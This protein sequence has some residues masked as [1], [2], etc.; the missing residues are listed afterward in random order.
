MGLSL[1]S[2]S[3]KESAAEIRAMV[4]KMSVGMTGLISARAATVVDMVP[5]IW[6]RCWRSGPDMGGYG[7]IIG[8]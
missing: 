6:A 8:D 2:G 5:P 3:R 1:V 7:A 4:A